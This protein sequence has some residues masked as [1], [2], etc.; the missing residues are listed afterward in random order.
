MVFLLIDICPSL[1]IKN[2][3]SVVK[4]NLQ[5]LVPNLMFEPDKQPKVVPT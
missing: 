1:T 3:I 4:K 2:E 5:K